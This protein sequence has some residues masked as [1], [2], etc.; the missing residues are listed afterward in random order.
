MGDFQRP[1]KGEERPLSK[2]IASPDPL[3]SHQQ[4][5]EALSARDQPA[6]LKRHE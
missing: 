6:R 5:P 4:R 2:P 1:T 3:L